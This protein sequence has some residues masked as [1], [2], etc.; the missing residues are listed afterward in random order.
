MSIDVADRRADAGADL[1]AGAAPPKDEAGPPDPP[2]HDV[3]QWL[4]RAWLPVSIAAAAIAIAIGL[5]IVGA[6][7]VSRPLDPND[8]SPA[9][10]RAIV[11]LLRDQGIAVTTVRD[12]D[13]LATTGDATV[14]VSAPGVLGP[15]ELA[16]L[17]DSHSDLVVIAPEDDALSALGVPAQQSGDLS[18]DR[19]E[20]RCHL[21]AATTAGS[22]TVDGPVYTSAADVELCYPVAGQNAVVVASRNGRRITVVGSRAVFANHT[23]DQQGNA[24][25]ALGLL[26]DHRRLDWLVPVAP[27]E[28]TGTERHGLFELLPGRLWWAL[29]E[30]FVALLLFALSRGRRLGP[31]VTEA[32]PVVVRATET[33]EGRARLLRAARARRSGA[34]AL[35]S[36]V[37]RRLGVRLGLGPAPSQSALVDR[38]VARTGRGAQTVTDLLYGSSP[39]DDRTL[40][41]LATAL[42]QLEEEMRRQ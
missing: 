38:V 34:E 18:D 16:T 12:V 33:V 20:P 19:V 22:I 17:A 41:A 39:A 7:P 40:V 28:A 26:T 14:V 2:R 35:R 11:A 42:D 21:P 29:L 27:T 8:A 25:L 36:G 6:A 30:V 13:A 4:R 9:G 10:A 24:A 32:L 15:D 1:D 5:A 23:L 37:R 31:L 3:I